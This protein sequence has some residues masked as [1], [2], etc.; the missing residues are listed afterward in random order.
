MSPWHK[1]NRGRRKQSINFGIPA[2]LA[3]IASSGNLLHD[4]NKLIKYGAFSLRAHQVNSVFFKVH[5]KPSFQDTLHI[6]Y[7][8]GSKH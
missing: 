4:L 2:S 8:E 1:M 3:Y 6:P 5:K 7:L